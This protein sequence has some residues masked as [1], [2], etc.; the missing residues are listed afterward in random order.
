MEAANAKKME[1]RSVVTVKSS[2]DAARRK[3]FPHRRRTYAG[4]GIGSQLMARR[5]F[6]LVASFSIEANAPSA[7]QGVSFAFINICK[8]RTKH[9][10]ENVQ[11]RRGG[12]ECVR[13]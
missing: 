9:A 13:I 8:R 7:Q 3:C 2:Q 4:R 5:T 6:T 11:E 10:C 12:G 1:T